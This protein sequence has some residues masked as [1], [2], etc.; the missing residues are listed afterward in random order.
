MSD[1][2]DTDVVEISERQTINA[3]LRDA[4]KTIEQLQKEVTKYKTR[5]KASLDVI[6]RLKSV[7]HE[8]PPKDKACSHKWLCG[9]CLYCKAPKEDWEPPEEMG[10][11]SG[12]PYV[13]NGQPEPPREET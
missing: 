3:A 8:A 1:V 5:W 4:I 7:E 11:D 2:N 12:V 9:F 6:E 10:R 13:T